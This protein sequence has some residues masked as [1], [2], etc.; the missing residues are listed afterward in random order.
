MLFS[1]D[2]ITQYSTAFFVFMD[3]DAL[4][5]MM[6]QEDNYYNVIFSDRELDIEPGRL[7]STLRR[8]AVVDA[9]GIFMEQDASMIYVMMGTSA[10]I[11][12]LVVYLMLGVMIDH[13]SYDISL[14]KV[15]GYRDREIRGMYLN[16]S[17]ACIALGTL[18]VLPLAKLSMDLCYPFL[19]MNV[20][21]SMDVS[22]PWYVLPA[23][24]VL[25]MG[26][27]F[28]IVRVLTGKIRKITPAEVLKNR[29]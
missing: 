10:A 22:M 24:Y 17:L 14:M 26:I 28:A 21:S 8:Q 7:Q 18:V 20:A 11:L 2:E 3:I 29:E 23:I 4:R 16:G 19:I 13:A 25:V 9:A 12:V 27:S 1:V 15:F 5:E 6:G